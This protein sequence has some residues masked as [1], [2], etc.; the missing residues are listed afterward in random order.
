MQDS[1]CGIAPS[2]LERIFEP[3]FT[4]KEVGH[5]AGLGLSSARGIIQRHG[6]TLTVRSQLGKGSTFRVSL[7]TAPQGPPPADGVLESHSAAMAPQSP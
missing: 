5:G 6:G 1:G 7:P 4:T 2:D 3:F